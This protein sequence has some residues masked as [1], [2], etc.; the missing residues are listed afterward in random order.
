VAT[1]T[2]TSEHYEPITREEMDEG[3]PSQI[4]SLEPDPQSLKGIRLALPMGPCPEEPEIVVP[5]ELALVVK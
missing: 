3:R 2:Y 4:G 1:V 5:L